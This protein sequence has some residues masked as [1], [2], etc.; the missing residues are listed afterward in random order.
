MIRRNALATGAIHLTPAG[1]MPPAELCSV[2][3]RD[4]PGDFLNGEVRALVS[5]A[6]SHTIYSVVEIRRMNSGVGVRASGRIQWPQRWL[7]GL[8]ARW[9][10]PCV[11]YWIGQDLSGSLGVSTCT[12]LPERYFYSSGSQTF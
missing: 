6:K 8:E 5:A 12:S 3:G 9:Q 10:A 1:L 7:R 4:P 2:T 11:L